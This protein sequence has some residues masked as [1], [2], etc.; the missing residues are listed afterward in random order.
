MVP[1]DKTSSL[2]STGG[3]TK[4]TPSPYIYGPTASGI[5]ICVCVWVGGCGCV[6]DGVQAEQMTAATFFHFPQ[7]CGG[8]GRGEGG[9]KFRAIKGRLAICHFHTHASRTTRSL[10]ASSGE[11]ETSQTYIIVW[12]KRWDRIA[13]E[14]QCILY[15]WYRVG[16]RIHSEATC[17]RCLIYDAI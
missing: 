6:W 15:V 10:F 14:M 12:P 1:K 5:C 11:R 7:G 4:A 16:R 8:V 13:V 3:Q 2:L 9:G 17:R